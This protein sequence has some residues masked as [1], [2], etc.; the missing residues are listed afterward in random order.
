VNAIGVTKGRGFGGVVKRHHFR[1][2]DSTHGARKA[3]AFGGDRP[4]SFQEL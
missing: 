3:Q 4:A 2:G 1:G